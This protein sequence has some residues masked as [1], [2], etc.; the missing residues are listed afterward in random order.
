MLFLPLSSVEGGQHRG[1]YTAPSPLDVSWVVSPCATSYLCLEHQ[2]WA[3]CA[4]E[5]S[6]KHG[7]CKVTPVQPK[8][9]AALPSTGSDVPGFDP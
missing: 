4:R 9:A 1:A 2:G 6:E 5:S 7:L 3:G 8:N